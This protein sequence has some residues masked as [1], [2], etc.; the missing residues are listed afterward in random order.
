MAECATTRKD[1]ENAVKLPRVTDATFA[2]E[3][4]GNRSFEMKP[5]RA[6]G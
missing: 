3:P 5:S 1:H 4:N 6:F 2:G